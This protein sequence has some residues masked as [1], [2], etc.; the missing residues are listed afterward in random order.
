MREVSAFQPSQSSSLMPSS[1]ETSDA[2]G[3]EVGEE[4]DHLVGAEGAPLE[5]IDAVA[6]ELGGGDIQGDPD[7]VAEPI[8]RRLDALDEEVDG[9]L[10]GRE[11]GGETALVADIGG[12]PP[13]REH[14]FSA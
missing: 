14:P 11:I 13:S 3:G 4:A 9:G 8:T 1:I 7:L 10:V 6:I 5:V 12:E 2:T